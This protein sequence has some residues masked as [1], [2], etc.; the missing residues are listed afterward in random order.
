MNLK[1]TLTSAGYPVT[2]AVKKSYKYA[3]RVYSV[4]LSMS[5]LTNAQALDLFKSVYAACSDWRDANDKRAGFNVSPHG[6][7]AEQYA[8]VKAD[9]DGTP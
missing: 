8:S 2:S 7:T 9:L 5:G 6:L 4:A 1:D 3:G